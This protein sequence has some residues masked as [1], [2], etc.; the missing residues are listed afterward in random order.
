M[1]D[2][3]IT[4][5]NVVT[6]LTGRSSGIAGE[7]I[8]AG[9]L[10]YIKAAD[11]KLYLAQADGATAAEAVVVGMALNSA[12]AGQPVFYQSSG[13]I[14]VGA[15]FAAAG[16]VLILA[17]TAGKC[18][19]AADITTGDYLTIV[20]YSSSTVAAVLDITATGLEIA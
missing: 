15:V 7:A 6:S 17:Q 14:T 11:S 12:A 2:Y 20:G 18:C 5:S 19:D 10:L 4:A 3:T 16:Q 8:A 9:Q 13:A 1:A